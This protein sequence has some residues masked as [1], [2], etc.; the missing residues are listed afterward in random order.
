M[1]AFALKWRRVAE[2]Y[3][4]RSAWNSPHSYI[5]LF[6]EPDALPTKPGTADQYMAAA[7]AVKYGLV[8]SNSTAGAQPIIKLLCGVV[9]DSVHDGW[10]DA[11]ANGLF[12]V[13][14]GFSFHTYRDPG[15][16]E[17]LVAVFRNWLAFRGHPNFPLVVTEAGSPDLWQSETKQARTSTSSCPAGFFCDSGQCK[18]KMRPTLE[19]DVIYAWDLIVKAIEHK[20]LG[21]DASFMFILFYYSESKGCY[22][23]TGRD[24]T[25]LRALAALAQ[26]IS[27]LSNANYV[28]DL[29]NYGWRVFNTSNEGL[30]AVITAAKPGSTLKG[31]SGAA[32]KWSW[33]YPVRKLEGV[34]GRALSVHCYYDAGCTFE[35]VDG[36]MYAY[37]DDAAYSVLQRHT[38][39]SQLSAL[40]NTAPP[41]PGL[42]GGPSNARVPAARNQPQPQRQAAPLVMRYF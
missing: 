40:A 33:Y 42:L 18:G 38:V 15:D 28:G 31:S 2:D 21:I 10:R 5:E 39:A 34:D 9:T 1:S 36:L 26:A 22:S 8:H 29:P 14:D 19:E 11:A 7:Q 17:K 3:P 30:V 6:N 37:L 25:A 24:G 35:N 4:A 13:R 20:A 41:L 27:V 12:E 23:I 32:T 16:E